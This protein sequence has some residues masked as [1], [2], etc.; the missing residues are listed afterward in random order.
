MKSALSGVVV[1]ALAVALQSA[2]IRQITLLQG[3]AD[4]VLLTLAA[5]YMH[6]EAPGSWVWAVIAGLMVGTLSALP[7]WLYVVGYGGLAAVA[8]FLRRRL[9]Q[10]SYFAYFFLILVGCALTLGL[11]WAYLR[12]VAGAGIPLAPTLNRVFF[13]SLLLDVLFALPV[14]SL[15]DEWAAWFFAEEPAL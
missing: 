12:F 11:S 7:W 6:E 9:W 4:L 2:I 1:L 15:M 14:Y 3:S 10:T 8:L 13:P 5:W